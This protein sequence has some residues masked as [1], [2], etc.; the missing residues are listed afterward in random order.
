MW[1]TRTGGSKRVVTGADATYSITCTDATNSFT[2]ADAKHS[3]IHWCWR[4]VLVISVN[5]EE[6]HDLCSCVEQDLLHDAGIVATTM[7]RNTRGVWTQLES[8]SSFRAN[9]ILGTFM[10]T[11]GRTTNIIGHHA[12]ASPQRATQN[13]RSQPDLS[14]TLAPP[15]FL[16]LQ[17]DFPSASKSSGH[18]A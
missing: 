4:R 1:T 14:K 5:A 3:V 17:S 7:S 9:P 16:S 10:T 8:E 6:V 12:G 13:K 15:P 18:N 11:E 2:G